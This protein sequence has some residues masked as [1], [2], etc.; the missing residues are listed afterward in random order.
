L[1]QITNGK[2]YELVEDFREHG[3]DL[4]FDGNLDLPETSELLMENAEMKAKSALKQRPEYHFALG[5]DSGVFI[6]ALDYMP[7]VHSRRWFGEENDDHGRN[8]KILDLMKNET[9]RTAYLISRFAL[10]N[11]DGVLIKTSVKNHF[12]IAYSERGKKGFGYDNILIPTVDSEE[13]SMW[14]NLWEHGL[15]DDD[16]MAVFNDGDFDFLET[17]IGQMTQ[18]QKNLITFRGRIAEEIKTQ[19]IE[20]GVWES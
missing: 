3:M 8:Q 11:A 2:Y 16:V 4:I 10:V 7:G 19:L 9:N 5:D 13:D 6:E 12:L 20:E 1:H 14:K 17:T 15:S 18:E